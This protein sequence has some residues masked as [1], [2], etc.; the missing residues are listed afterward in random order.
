[1]KSNLYTATGSWAT[2]QTNQMDYVQIAQVPAATLLAN[3][4]SD[5]YL[6]GYVEHDKMP[7]FCKI[8]HPVND[9]KN[10]HVDYVEENHGFGFCTLANNEWFSH[11]IKKDGTLLTGANNYYA[12]FINSGTMASANYNLRDSDTIQLSYVGICE[13]LDYAND[14]VIFD[15]SD[16][17][18][19]FVYVS[20]TNWIITCSELLNAIT[21]NG[22][23]T[24]TINNVF[25]A[26]RTFKI[27]PDDHNEYNLYSVVDD[28]NEIKMYFHFNFI[29]AIPQQTDRK[30]VV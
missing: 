27:H 23:L 22:Y 10:F 29:V 13:P 9:G 2:G 28:L 4:L 1:M 5:P 3:G 17:G 26:T 15:S 21:N 18:T 25:G 12:R 16:S 14:N 24:L 11:A 19:K 6:M 20:G 7:G 8:G 30:S